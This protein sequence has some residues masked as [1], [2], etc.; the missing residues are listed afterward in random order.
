MKKSYLCSLNTIYMKKYYLLLCAAVLLST[1]SHLFAEKVSQ[2]T[3]AQV[4]KNFYYE[5]TAF[6]GVGYDRISVLESFDIQ[7]DG[8]SVYYA[9]N[10]V[11]GGFVIVS[12]DDL[13]TPIIGYNT[14]GA[15][16][17]TDAPE[18]W[19]WLMN[20][21][22][23]MIAFGREQQ[24]ASNP[25]Y[26]A[27]WQHLSVDDPSLLRG[28]R[29]VV[30]PPLCP[31]QWNQNHPY[32]YYA[33][34]DSQGP[35]GRA[36][37]G[38][39]ATA[40]SIIMHYWRWPRQGTGSHSYNP[41]SWFCPGSNYPTLSVSFGD[42]EYHFDGM[43]NSIR[44]GMDN[45]VALLM[46]HCGVAVDM[47]YCASGS[48][49]FSED[50]PGAIKSYFK[51]DKS[52]TL[53]DKDM[54]SD[55]QWKDLLK[56]DLDKGFPMYNSGNSSAGGH[57]FVCDGY[58]SD[59]LFHYNFGWG[60]SQNGYYTVN[61]V[62]GFHSWQSVIVN[63]IPDKDQYPYACPELTIVPFSEGTIA[64]CSGPV[65]NYSPDISSSWLIDPNAGGDLSEKIIIITW[66][67]L[68]LAQDDYLTIYDGEN[69]ES[70]VLAQYTADSQPQ[71]IQSTGAK[72][73]IRFTTSPTSETAQGFMLNFKIKAVKTCNANETTTLTDPE[74]TFED[75]SGENYFYPN[76]NYC[77]W[78]IEP[79]NATNLTI[80]F[81][82]F[83]TETGKDIV[84][85][86]DA[87]TVKT[88]ATLSGF[89]SPSNLP[90]VTV[91]SGRALVTFSS[92][93]TVNAKG[94]EL[95]YKAGYTTGVEEQNQAV[96]ALTAFPNPTSGNLNLSFSSHNN[97]NIH[98][99]I[100]N[101]TG[102]NIYHERLTD[103]SGIY[104]KTINTE[105]FP[106]GVYFLRVT[107][108]NGVSVKKI[109]VD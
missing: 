27:M 68:D 67:Q 52:A 104:R 66:E 11:D 42:T 39:V 12:A 82:Y 44:V 87:E 32:N 69:E 46:Y 15:Y 86:Y 98:I 91:P 8:N 34:L 45:P 102:Q 48:G 106:Q 55:Q 40:M 89:Y 6:R 80:T 36:Y 21:F 2:Q 92:D 24:L 35:G 93:N 7:R 47:M 16:S 9:F 29:D 90:T 58:D 65:H 51:Y 18:N 53:Y 22:A 3:A 59:D 33:P 61:N 79:E 109:M 78:M 63:Y 71:E 19:Q 43:T 56:T 75:G 60:G 1:T 84:K 62:N 94:F 73:F 97:D 25:D 88:V 28:G 31:A 50:V 95:N 38:C 57:A 5:T 77:R 20:E 10:F 72:V 108:S 96:E 70:P 49:A 74:G 83:E 26:A 4:A 103:F 107:S 64:D 41:N 100:F 85:I 76:S 30:V 14:E 54:M 81:N 101:I 105:S 23:E 13:Y 17:E 99:E 37:A